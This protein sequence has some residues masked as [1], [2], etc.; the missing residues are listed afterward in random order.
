[1]M[2]KVVGFCN[3]HG[4]GGLGKHLLSRIFCL[5][6]FLFF[7]RTFYFTGNATKGYDIAIMTMLQGE[8]CKVV[9]APKYWY[10]A[11]NSPPISP[12]SVVEDTIELFEW[13]VISILG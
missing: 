2:Q 10:G 5:Y 8:K 13:E 7:K 3:L 4:T 6:H 11:W 1:M 9:C 12:N